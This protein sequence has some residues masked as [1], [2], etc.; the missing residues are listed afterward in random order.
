MRI[1]LKS[2]SWER[3]GDTLVLVPEPSRKIEL[4]DSDGTSETLLCVLQGQAHSSATLCAALQ[5][6]GISAAPHEIA[7]CVQSLDELGL[8]EDADEATL[9]QRDQ[10]RYFSNLAFLEMFSDL[11]VSA[12][13]MQRR[14]RSS[15]VVVLGAGGLGSNALQNIAGLGV[16]RVTVLDHDHVEPRNFA[17]QFIYRDTDVGHS[18]VERAGTWIREFDPSIEV[19]TVDRLVAGVADLAD[20]LDDADIVVSGI[21]QPDDVDSWVNEACMLANVPWVRGGM[22]GSEIHYFS[23]APNRSACWACRAAAHAQELTGDDADSAANRLSAEFPRLNRGIGPAATMLGALVSFEVMRYLTDFEKPYAAGALVR[24]ALVDGISH[25][26][27]PWP[28]D[29]GCRLCALIA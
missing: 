2:I 6:R 20:L 16:G 19:R 24:V 28:Q 17:R 12:V 15:H 29:P 9:P 5:I 25:R 21:D 11:R 4:H 1:R 10:S 8:L 26:R 18:K 22:V 3:V 7:S 23:V 14:L 13:E 27:E